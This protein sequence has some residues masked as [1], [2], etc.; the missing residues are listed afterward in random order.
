M[1]VLPAGVNAKD[2]TRQIKLLKIGEF[3]FLG[4]WPRPEVVDA[5][6]ALVDAGLLKCWETGS[7]KEQYTCLNFRRTEKGD[8]AL[9]QLQK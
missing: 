1:N 9:R 6:A 3:C 5:T 8:E 7:D 2:F 4:R